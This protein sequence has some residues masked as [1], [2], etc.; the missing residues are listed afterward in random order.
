MRDAVTPRL[1]RDPEGR[2]LDGAS[3]GG[4]RQVFAFFQYRGKTWR[5]HSDTH[6]E[7][8]LIAYRAVQSDP[9][10][11]PFEERPTA[12]GGTCLELVSELRQQQSGRHKHLYIYAN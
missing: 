5:V 7:P 10:F 8:L 9:T 4:N 1:N 12:Q 2:R 3:T 6:F 11:D